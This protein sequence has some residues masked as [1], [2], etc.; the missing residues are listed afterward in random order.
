MIHS[1]R[2]RTSHFVAVSASLRSKIGSSQTRPSGIHGRRKEPRDA[3]GQAERWTTMCRKPRRNQRTVES[4]RRTIVPKRVKRRRRSHSVFIGCNISRGRTVSDVPRS[5]LGGMQS[6]R[7]YELR[8]E[9]YRKR[10]FRKIQ[11]KEVDSVKAEGRDIAEES[12]GAKTRRRAS[13]GRSRAM[14]HDT[15]DGAEAAG[16][17]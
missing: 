17:S 9:Y 10:I 15:V 1:R 7:N 5:G 14:E 12:T 6:P 8:T 11:R 16:S 2:P 13:I 4:P 3:F